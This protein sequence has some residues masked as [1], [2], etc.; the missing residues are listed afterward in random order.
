MVVVSAAEGVAVVAGAEG[1][2]ADAR[3][4]SPGVGTHSPATHSSRYS[5]Q[6]QTLPVLDSHTHH[7]PSIVRSMLAHRSSGLAAPAPESPRSE[8]GP[9]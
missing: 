7:S 3:T 1:V 4:H 9:R 8:E 6:D 5:T 2:A